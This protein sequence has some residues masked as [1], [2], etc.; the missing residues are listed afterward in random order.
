MKLLESLNNGLK[1][2]I[3][4]VGKIFT[5]TDEHYPAT[6]IIPYTGE[7]YHQP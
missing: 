3:E 4:G 5:P 7:P 6:G 1:F 2:I